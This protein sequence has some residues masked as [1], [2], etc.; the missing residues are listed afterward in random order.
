M[1]ERK[2]YIGNIDTYT[3]IYILDFPFECQDR[4]NAQYSLSL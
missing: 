1:F 2:N 4:E 3:D